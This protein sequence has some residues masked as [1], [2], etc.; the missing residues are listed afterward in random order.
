MRAAFIIAGKDLRE[1]IR[2][3]SAIILAIIAPLG[4]ATIFSLL[5]PAGDEGFS[6]ELRIRRPRRQRVI[7][8]VPERP[9]RRG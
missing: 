8:R 1:R 3:R 5:L 4:L 6:A 7:G 2:D 9:A